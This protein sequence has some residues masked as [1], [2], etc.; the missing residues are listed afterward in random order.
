M[1]LVLKKGP[2]QVSRITTSNQGDQA[3]LQN[4]T[5]TKCGGGVP[6]ESHV[7]KAL[8]GKSTGYRFFFDACKSL[9]LPCLNNTTQRALETEFKASSNQ[10]SLTLNG[11][12]F[13]FSKL[14]IACRISGTVMEFSLEQ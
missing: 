13:S 1:V 5:V 8:D 12:S 2:N 7:D 14:L 10:D 11:I 3:Y 4:Q 9:R 6:F